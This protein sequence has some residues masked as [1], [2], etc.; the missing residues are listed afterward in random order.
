MTAVR[1]AEKGLR[2][3]LGREP[4]WEETSDKLPKMPTDVDPINHNGIRMLNLDHPVGERGRTLSDV[5]EDTRHA[6]V[7][8]RMVATEEMD[9]VVDLYRQLG[10]QQR[11]VISCRFGLD[12]EQRLTLVELGKRIGKSREGV[13]QIERNA[14]RRLRELTTRRTFGPRGPARPAVNCNP[15]RRLARPA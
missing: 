6:P 15:A 9:R 11:T 2:D 3:D 7:V 10:Q 4:T 12:G 8:D 5:I 1:N 13:R 14:L